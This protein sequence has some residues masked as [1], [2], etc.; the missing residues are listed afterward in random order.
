MTELANGCYELELV[1]SSGLRFVLV[2]CL[3]AFGGLCVSMQTI[4]VTGKLGIGLYFPGKVLQCCIS[5]SIAC[6]L[7]GKTMGL[8]P[9]MI[10]IALSVFLRRK[11]KICRNLQIIDV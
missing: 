1:G 7:C 5:I 6:I 8:M 2:S 4:S 10:A 3:L 9:A 11:Q